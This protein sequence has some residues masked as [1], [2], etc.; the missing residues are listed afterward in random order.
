[1]NVITGLSLYTDSYEQNFKQSK[2]KNKY[3]SLTFFSLFSLLFF[4][5]L[6]LIIVYYFSEYVYSLILYLGLIFIF[7]GIVMNIIT[8]FCY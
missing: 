1:M 8:Y 5:G 4:I 2:H 3:V 7:I 6:I